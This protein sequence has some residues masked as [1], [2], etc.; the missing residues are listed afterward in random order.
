MSRRSVEEQERIAKAMERLGMTMGVFVAYA[1]FR[2][3]DFISGNKD[4]QEPILQQIR[5]SVELATTAPP[6]CGW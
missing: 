2:S 6:A 1:D 4:R 3:T 5:D